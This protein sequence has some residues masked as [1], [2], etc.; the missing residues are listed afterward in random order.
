M[1][2]LSTR[3][4]LTLMQEYARMVVQNHNEEELKAML[5]LGEISPL[6]KE[7][8][9]KAFS[10]YTFDLNRP[11]F[12]FRYLDHIEIDTIWRRIFSG[13]DYI[14]LSVILRDQ[15]D[16]DITY[17]ELR[18]SYSI[19]D[20]IDLFSLLRIAN[21]QHPIT[22]LDVSGNG[23]NESKINE[24]RL[25]LTERYPEIRIRPEINIPL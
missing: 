7:L 15:Y 17:Y 22:V 14:D 1:A 21:D 23:F 25:Y 10:G 9:R 6:F 4:S 20:L 3:D 18:R 12:C 13:R 2:Q 16:A 11:D 5:R 8:I 24:I 19:P